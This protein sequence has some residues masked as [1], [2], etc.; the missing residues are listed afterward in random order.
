MRAEV[1]LLTRNIVVQGDE[2]SERDQY[3]VHIMIFGDDEESSVG[4]ILYTEIRYAG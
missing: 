3:G 4:R 1:G 2:T